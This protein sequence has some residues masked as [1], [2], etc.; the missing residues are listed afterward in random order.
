MYIF[1]EYK[2]IFTMTSLSFPKKISK[3]VSFALDSALDSEEFPSKPKPALVAVYIKGSEQ[4]ICS[5]KTAAEID[6]EDALIF[7]SLKRSSNGWKPKRNTPTT[8]E[9]TYLSDENDLEDAI[10]V[11]IQNSIK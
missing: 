4:L 1:E 10:W 3:R 9:E 2:P 11:L 6:E 5:I 8:I 7:R